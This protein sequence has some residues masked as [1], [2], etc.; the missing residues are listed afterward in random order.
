MNITNE[1]Q[2]KRAIVEDE[3]IDLLLN[4]YDRFV[5]HG[6][7]AVWRCYGGNRFSRDIDFYSNFGPEE[8]SLFQKQLHK[9]LMDNGYP[10]RE[11]KYNNKTKTL[12]IIFRGNDTTGKLDIT[13][14][15]AAGAAV[16]YLRVDGAKRIIRALSAESLLEEKINA[17]LDK[18]R[19]GTHEIQ[20]LYDILILK[21]KIGV[22]SK[23]V[24]EKIAEFLGKIKKDP[25]SDEKVLRQLVLDGIAPTFEEMV[26]FINR[27]LNDIG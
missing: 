2:L 23:L 3:I 22:P 16:E 11:E 21:D 20:D 4:H 18:H 17:Y 24:R 19:T 5:M 12:H 1:T 15:K 9:L 8:E 26:G 6:G 25:P 13:F 14:S 7:T 27:W 10:V